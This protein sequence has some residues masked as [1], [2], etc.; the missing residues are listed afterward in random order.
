MPQII[1]LGFLLFSLE[2]VI[3]EL[4]TIKELRDKPQYYKKAGMISF[5]LETA[6]PTD[7]DLWETANRL[8]HEEMGIS[9]SEIEI[10]RLV[11]RGFQ[12]IPGRRDILTFYAYGLFHG[13]TTQKIIPKD[14]DIEFAGWKSIPEL[15]K[16]FIRVEVSPIL[17]H[18]LDNGYYDEIITNHS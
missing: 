1:G 5:P 13:S 11:E 3:P 12:L 8:F 18:L 15:L 10:L 17:F 16:S 6:E 14:D 4:F 7:K 2:N 9:P